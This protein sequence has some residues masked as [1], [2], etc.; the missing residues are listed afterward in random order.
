[1]KDTVVIE[2]KRS[3]IDKFRNWYKEKL[4]D[5]G[6][7]QSFEENLDKEIELEKQAIG[8]IGTIATVVLAFCPADG[9]VGEICTALAT[10]LLQSLVDLK[11]KITREVAIG[12]KRA[13]EANLI[14]ADGSSKQVQVADFNL[15]S[16][17]TDL[18][19]AINISNQIS[20]IL[21]STGGRSL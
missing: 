19:D 20:D 3:V 11:G 8:I 14:K 4:I 12:G 5:T 17:A 18:D 6:K 1:M 2:E 15:E 10:P 13:L 16:I 9:P 7:A 21:P